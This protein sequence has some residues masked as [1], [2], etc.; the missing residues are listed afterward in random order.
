MPLH[1]DLYP[2]NI[3]IS[4][5]TQTLDD[6]YTAL[7]Y[8]LNNPQRPQELYTKNKDAFNNDFYQLSA[9]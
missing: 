2:S 8:S 9:L 7:Y 4:D 6:Y 1:P 3:R 5:I